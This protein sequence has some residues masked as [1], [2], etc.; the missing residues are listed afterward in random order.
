[1]KLSITLAITALAQSCV[2]DF[3]VYE[4]GGFGDIVPVTYFCFYHNPPS[5][6]DLGKHG[7]KCYLPYDNV[8]KRK[9]ISCDGNGCEGGNPNEITRFE[10]NVDWGH[11]TIYKDRGNKMYDTSDRVVGQC[12]PDRSK[13]WWCLGKGLP[14]AVSV[15][16][17]TTSVDKF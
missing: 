16:H 9:G 12:R 7:S 17:C 11:Y 15:F 10:M 1:M 4:A 6:G 2:A 8:S 13:S 5:C 3:W 14:D